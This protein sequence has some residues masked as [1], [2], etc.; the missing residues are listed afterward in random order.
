MHIAG[1]D[2]EKVSD[3]DTRRLEELGFF[4]S[5]SN[6]DPEFMSYRYGSA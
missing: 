6:G 3:E 2:P 4:V 1:I 5:E